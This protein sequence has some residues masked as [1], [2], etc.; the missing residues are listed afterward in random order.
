LNFELRIFQEKKTHTTQTQVNDLKNKSP[1]ISYLVL[2]RK[3]IDR[4]AKRQQL[5]WRYFRFFYTCTHSTT[6]TKE[7][8]KN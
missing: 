6:K 1:E 7:N 8:K 4:Y 5:E 3:T 2:T